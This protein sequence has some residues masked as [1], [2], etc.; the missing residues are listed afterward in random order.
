MVKDN[1]VPACCRR[2]VF[3]LRG[4][5]LLHLIHTM[6]EMW[7]LGGFSG[8][9]AVG[10]AVSCARCGPVEPFGRACL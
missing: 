1:C 5:G 7:I 6:G 9:S 2:G 10:D 8:A 4:L 3:V